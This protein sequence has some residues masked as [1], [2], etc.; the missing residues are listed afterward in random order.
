[1][2]REFSYLE[3]YPFADDDR[4]LPHFVST[5]TMIWMTVFGILMSGVLVTYYTFIYDGYGVNNL[6]NKKVSYRNDVDLEWI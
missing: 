4:L 2:K 5:G 1:M 3:D 6:M